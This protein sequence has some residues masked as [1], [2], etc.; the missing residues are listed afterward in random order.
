M[1]VE[2]ASRAKALARVISWLLVREAIVKR[3]RKALVKMQEQRQDLGKTC[4]K[5]DR[6]RMRNTRTFHALSTCISQPGCPPSPLS[7]R[8]RQ[9]TT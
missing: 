6:Y 1:A 2:E 7:S 4:Q 5:G 3:E 9:P 8:K